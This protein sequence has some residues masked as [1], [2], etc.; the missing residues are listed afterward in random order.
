MKDGLLKKK[1]KSHRWIMFM[2]LDDDKRDFTENVIKN[3]TY[4]V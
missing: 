1:W 3:V 2:Y 4:L